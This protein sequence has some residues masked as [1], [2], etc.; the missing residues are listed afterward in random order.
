MAAGV[1]YTRQPPT[2]RSAAGAALSV[3]GCGQDA[4]GTGDAWI[5]RNDRTPLEP[6]VQSATGGGATASDFRPLGQLSDGDEGQPH[7]PTQDGLSDPARGPPLVD[8][9]RHVGV[10]NNARHE[11]SGESRFSGG[12]E[13]S[14]EGIEFLVG[15]PHVEGELVERPEGLRADGARD[16]VQVRILSGLN[17]GW[18]R[19]SWLRGSSPMIYLRAVAEAGEAAVLTLAQLRRWPLAPLA[20]T[21]VVYVVENPSLVADAAGR[22]RAGPPVICSSGRPTVAVVTALRQ[23]GAGGAALRQHADFDPAGL[24]ITAWLA[25]RAGTIPWR[26]SA[27]DYLGAA[28]SD[29]THLTG[30]VPPTPWDPTLAEAMSAGGVIAYEEDVRAGLLDAMGY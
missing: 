23:L 5:V 18:G 14:E 9:R 4:P 30:R 25:A 27:D 10:D 16:G 11:G 15:F 28:R 29:G 17:L 12:P 24:G 19:L 8:G 1:G 3:G 22:H 21:E 6:V 7:L 2:C 26:M 13:V 20:S